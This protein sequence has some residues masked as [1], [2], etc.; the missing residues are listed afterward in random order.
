MW[1][2]KA[3][4]DL[5]GLPGKESPGEQRAREDAAGEIPALAA[6]RV[7]HVG[8]EVECVE[9]EETFDRIR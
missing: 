1:I 9:E 2:G 3:R 5:S 4:R 8:V 6:G 7:R